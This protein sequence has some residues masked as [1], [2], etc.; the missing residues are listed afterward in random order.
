MEVIFDIYDIERVRDRRRRNRRGN[1]NLRRKIFKGDLFFELFAYDYE[2]AL[3]IN[4]YSSIW[5]SIC[6]KFYFG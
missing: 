4:K 1:N 5:G 6:E 2:I 3:Y